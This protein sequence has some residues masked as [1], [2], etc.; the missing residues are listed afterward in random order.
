MTTNSAQSGGNNP[1]R[2]DTT[3]PDGAVERVKEFLLIYGD[4]IAFDD[5]IANIVLSGERSVLRASDLTSL[6]EKIETQS[7]EIERLR[8]D[9]RLN[10]AL[11]D[12]Q[13]DEIERLRAALEAMRDE[14]VDKIKP[15]GAAV[16][17]GGFLNKI[18]AA[19]Q[20]GV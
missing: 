3:K 7:A 14:L 1:M 2:P 11:I 12:K 16:I 6:L 15:N 5:P 8:R 13:Q 4:V 10:D 9:E 20:G 18:D 19:L 17:D